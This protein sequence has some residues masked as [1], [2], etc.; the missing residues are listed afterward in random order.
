MAAKKIKKNANIKDTNGK[1]QE[2][3]QALKRKKK[4]KKKRRER[5]KI[6]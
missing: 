6:R 2:K 3:D 5:E 4:Q 1:V